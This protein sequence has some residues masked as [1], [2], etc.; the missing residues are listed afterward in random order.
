VNEADLAI[1]DLTVTGM[2]CESCVRRVTAAVG[3]LAGVE[4]VN[5]HIGCVR[6]EFYPQAVSREGI[7]AAIRGLGYGIDNGGDDARR[8][9]LLA[10]MAR[11]NQ[12]L[13]GSRRLNC[14]T[15]N[16]PAHG[17]SRAARS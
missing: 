9:G 8:D 14:C 4:A 17:A 7:E 1:V 6:V 2:H 3:A 11:T 16:R 13:F 10:R 15:L 12:E 5:A